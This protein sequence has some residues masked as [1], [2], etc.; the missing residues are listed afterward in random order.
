MRKWKLV[1]FL[2]PFAIGM[3][4]CLTAQDS[5][6]ILEKNKI[7]VGEQITVTYHVSLNEGDKVNFIPFS[8]VIPA[9]NTED[10]KKSTELEIIE[11]FQDTILTVK[12]KKEWFGSYRI[13]CWDSGY[14]QLQT[15]EFS[16]NGKTNYFPSAYLSVDLTKKKQGVDLYDIKESFTKLPPK[17]FSLSESITDF[18]T[19]NKG[20]VYF[21]LALILLVVGYFWYKK[22]QKNKLLSEKIPVEKELTLREKT[23]LAIEKLDDKKLWSTGKLKEHYVEL[24]LILRNYLSSN[25]ELN[26]LEKT[27]YETKILLAKKGLN[28]AIIDSI[29]E[30]LDQSDMVKFA[31]SEPEEITVIRISSITKQIVEQTSPNESEHAE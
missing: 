8:S 4:F 29:G 19:E 18:Y 7:V 17:K 9:K 24:S 26:L 21:L 11:P 14:F 5:Q 28:S 20:W 23:L 31:K 27:S 2:V 6:T 22:R 16:L 25:Y 1:V 12:G 13:T 15:V 30:I 10:A 3:V